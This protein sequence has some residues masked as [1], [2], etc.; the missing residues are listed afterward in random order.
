MLFAVGLILLLLTRQVYAVQITLTWDDHN[1]NP[2]DVGGYRLYYWQAPG[3]T[4]AS[5]DVGKQTIYTL[6]GLAAGQTYS[7][8]VTA[9]N[10]SGGG[11]SADSNVVSQTFPA[12]APVAS[13]SA[14][15]STGT[16]P[17]N[18]T[19]TST[20]TGTITSWAWTFGDGGT[21]TAPNPS[22]T[23]TA[24][25]TYTVRLTVTGPDGAD[26]ATATLTVS[27]TP[28]ASL[29]AAYSFN[30]GSG[31]TVT[32]VSGYGNHGTITGATWTTAGKFGAALSF[33][34]TSNWVTVND[35]PP[36]TSRLA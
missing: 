33:N 20:S 14:T 17:L 16:V 15:P 13:F 24:V 35:P 36:S 1:N 22:Y 2:A 29:V 30:E 23:Y 27:P 34:G 26:T 6:S 9:Y 31:T 19:F 28:A 25:G 32:D 11:E 10:L 18:V 21:S 12:T 4:P 8:A 3:Q 7:F 5:F